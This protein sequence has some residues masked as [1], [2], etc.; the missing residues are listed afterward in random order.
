LSRSANPHPLFA[1]F[2]G[3]RLA[4]A[5]PAYRRLWLAAVLSR[6]GDTIN[7]AALPLVVLGLT[8][9]PGAV[10]AIVFTEGIGLIVGGIVAQMVADRLPPRQLLVVLD[11]IRAGAAAC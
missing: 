10:A 11:L 5:Q 1:A 4:L 8:R 9:T 7:F 2:A 6:T 3:Y